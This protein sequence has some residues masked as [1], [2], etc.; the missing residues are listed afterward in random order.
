MFQKVL[1]KKLI[2]TEGIRKQK[3]K[4]ARV[5]IMDSASL[6]PAAKTETGHPSAILEPNALTV[7]I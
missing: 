3:F 6:L 7:I 4:V 5:H 1:E 2:V